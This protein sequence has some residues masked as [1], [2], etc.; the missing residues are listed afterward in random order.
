MSCAVNFKYNLFLL[1]V[2]SRSSAWIEHWPSI[3]MK[4][5]RGRRFK[6]YRERL[7]EMKILFICKYNRFRSKVA[8]C[9]FNALN[10]NKKIKAES[11]GLL[12]DASR[13]YIEKNVLKIMSEK[14]YKLRGAPRQLTSRLVKDFD[15][16]IIV[17]DNVN[18]E[19]FQSYKGK[20]VKWKI[21]DCKACELGR[22]LE[23]VNEI[24]DRVKNLLTNI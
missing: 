12:R 2:S 3:N 8:E 9:I 1:K 20:I 4:E 22:I 18:K 17:A 16:V 14:G 13:Q 6:S 19:F 21:S 7:I 5:V 11:A 23:I 10:K 24:E 15:V